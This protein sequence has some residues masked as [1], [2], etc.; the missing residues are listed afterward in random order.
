MWA[1]EELLAKVS[2]SG[3][4]DLIL[5]SCAP[6]KIKVNGVLRSAG[7]QELT[8]EEANYKRNGTGV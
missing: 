2:S 3:G 7:D 8:T 6:P 1:I 5:T 4:S